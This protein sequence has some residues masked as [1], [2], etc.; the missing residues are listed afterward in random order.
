MNWNLP[1]LAG[2]LLCAAILPS[3]QSMSSGASGTTIYYPTVAEMERLEAQ[4]GMQ[5]R[6]TPAYTPE[7]G[8][9]GAY[10]PDTAP[11]A[12]LTPAPA[13]AT[14]PLETVQPAIPPQ[15]LTPELKQKLN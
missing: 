12:P 3:C 15:P 11:R 14:V 13:P 5:P 1:I 9:A 8:A 10:V 7:P 2:T 4:W 6:A